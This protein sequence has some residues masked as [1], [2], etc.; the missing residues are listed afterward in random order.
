M[1]THPRFN[2]IRKPQAIIPILF[3]L[4]LVWLPFRTP[5]ARGQASTTPAQRRARGQTPPSTPPPTPPPTTTQGDCGTTFAGT[6][7]TQQNSDDF[8]QITVNGEEATGIYSLATAQRRTLRGNIDDNEF[9]GEWSEPQGQRSG[10]FKATLYP[11]SKRISIT[12]DSNGFQVDSM[13]WLCEAVPVGPVG[14]GGTV[15]PTP[16]RPRVTSDHDTDNFQT[17]DSLSRAEQEAALTKRGPRLPI[18]YEA[19]DLSMR[20]FVR[21]GWP[22][23]LEYGLS[24]DQ[25]AELSITVE[26]VDS[27]KVSLEPGDHQRVSITLPDDFGRAPRVAKLHISAAGDFQLF[28]FGMGENGVQA[29]RKLDRK[30]DEVQL[31]MNKATPEVDSGYEP[32]ALFSPVPQAGTPLQINV[33]LPSTLKVKQ[34][35][36]N[37]IDFSFTSRADF[38]EGRWEWWRVTGLSHWQKVWQDGTGTISRNQTKSDHW[39]GIIGMARLVSLGSHSLRLLAWQSQGKDRSS[40]CAIIEPRLLVIE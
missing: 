37:R 8:W 2:L 6:W 4:A 23:V 22:M 20:V 27:F 11:G 24:S 18:E 28:G 25:P 9:Q 39:N 15:T 5:A 10:S 3:F 36:A 40:T 7:H 21:G 14:T 29:L 35:P 33:Q 19:G 30:V 1:T 26:G 34:T 12:F 16:K 32:L 13:V 31:A 17:F 38:S